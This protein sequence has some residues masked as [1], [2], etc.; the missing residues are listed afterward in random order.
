MIQLVGAWS[1]GGFS[2][3]A[4]T[5]PS[6]R[7][8]TTPNAEGSST[9]VSEIVAS[10]PRSSWNATNAAEVEVGEHVTVAD[11]Q[12]LVD[13]LGRE[14]DPARGAERLVFDDEAQLHV[15][16]A[17]VGEVAGERVGQVPERE[18]RFVDAVDREPVELAF[19]E[20]DVRDRQQWL[21]CRVRERTET[22]ARA[23]DEDD[24]FHGVSYWCCLPRWWRTTPWRTSAPG[25]TGQCGIVDDDRA[26]NGAWPPRS[27]ML[28]SA[29]SEPGG[30]SSAVP[31][32]TK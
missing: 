27:W 20:R 29:S 21:R 13:A 14:A 2:T 25:G 10:A 15:A 11:D 19:D 3:N 1:R 5:S 24:G 7:V 31:L 28:C 18:H 17:L 12:A 32:G 23:T 30:C 9:W 26:R 4:I 8:G 6:A 22:G 16:V